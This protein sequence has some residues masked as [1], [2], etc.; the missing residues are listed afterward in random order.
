MYVDLAPINRTS[1]LPREVRRLY[2]VPVLTAFL[3]E[4]RK[5]AVNKRIF[6]GLLS[7]ALKLQRF[8]HI[9]VIFTYWL[10]WWLSSYERSFSAF[11]EDWSLIP[12]A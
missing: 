12:S 4:D 6:H 8:N 2:L 11:P 7:N 5:H 3:W 10:E 1:S 9:P